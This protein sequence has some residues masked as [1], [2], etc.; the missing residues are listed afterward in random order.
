MNL[1]LDQIQQRLSRPTDAWLDH[2]IEAEIFKNK[3]TSCFLEQR[4]KEDL[5]KTLSTNGDNVLKKIE[6]FLELA[7]MAYLSYK[8]AT[9]EEKRD[10]V[11]IITSNLTVKEKNVS[12]KAKYPFKGLENRPSFTVG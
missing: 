8:M 1:Q 11:K 3:K 9:P 6:K 12:I 4:E 7:K 2:E 5:P 10:M